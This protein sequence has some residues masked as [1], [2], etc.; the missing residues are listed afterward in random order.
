MGFLNLIQNLIQSTLNYQNANS[1]IAPAM[2]MLLKKRIEFWIASV[3]DK[4]TQV[5]MDSPWSLRRGRMASGVD[6]H[7][8]IFEVFVS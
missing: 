3:A 5:A 1:L 2:R 7:P 6:A 4:G 8:Q